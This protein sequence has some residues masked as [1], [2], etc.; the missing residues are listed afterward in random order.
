M[1]FRSETYFTDQLVQCRC[2]LFERSMSTSLK[3]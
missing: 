2:L 1:I 3:R